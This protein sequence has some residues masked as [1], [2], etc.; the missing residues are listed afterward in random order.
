MSVRQIQSREFQGDGE[1]FTLSW[2]GGPNV[3]PVTCHASLVTIFQFLLP[4]RCPRDG[5]ASAPRGGVFQRTTGG[6]ATGLRSST[7]R[8]STCF[9]KLS[10]L[11]TCTVN[12]SPRRIVRRVR[13]PTR[14]LRAASNT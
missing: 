1:R 4:R 3:F 12:L 2:G 10:T 7:R 5:R 11:A 6:R 9:L 8:K 14:L 13:R